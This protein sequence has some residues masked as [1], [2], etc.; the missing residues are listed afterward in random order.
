MPQCVGNLNNQGYRR[1]SG[2]GSCLRQ[3]QADRDIDAAI[4]DGHGSVIR[5]VQEIARA[6]GWPTTWLNEQATPYMP[7][8]PDHH[9]QVVLDHPAL[10]V[11]VAS[12]LHM[13]AMKV[14]AARS[15]DVDDVRRLLHTT[16]LSTVEE[17]ELVVESVFPGEP[18]G[19]RRRRWLE[20]LL[21]E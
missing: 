20:D 16:G 3:R 7:P 15:T 6:R 17:V 12:P 14:R 5:A 9:A 18:L 21:E 4:I 13:L 11:L 19:G 10:K 8:A 1:R 2:D